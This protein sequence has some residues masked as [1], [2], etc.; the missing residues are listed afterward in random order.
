M[1]E[2]PEVAYLVKQMHK[3]FS[4]NTLT[5]IEFVKGRYV[6]QDPKGFD[7]LALPIKLEKIYHHGKVL[8]FEL[9]G[10]VYMISRLGLAGWWSWDGSE[11]EKRW[12]VK[13]DFDHDKTL[14][15]CDTMNYGTIEFVQDLVDVDALAPDVFGLKWPTFWK[16]VTELSA[17]KKRWLLEDIIVDQHTLVAGIGNYLKCEILYHAKLSPIRKAGE[18]EESEWKVLFESMKHI[19]LHM[20]DGFKKKG[21]TDSVYNELLHV[22]EKKMDIQGNAVETRKTKGGRTTYWVPSVQ[23]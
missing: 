21:V 23:I 10:G 6:K 4:Q 7:K 9:E 8:I 12:R 19:V 11:S 17:A 5:S 18:L 1:P 14:Y 20:H 16:R 13:F 3:A 2:A 22:Y 15:Y